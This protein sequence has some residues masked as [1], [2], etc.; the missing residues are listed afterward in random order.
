MPIENSIFKAYD[1]RG[2]YPDQ[3]NEEI[4]YKTG[5]ALVD[6]LKAKTIVVARDMRESSPSL[7]KQFIQGAIEQGAKVIDLDLASTPMFYFA[8]AH[9]RADGGAVITASHNPSKYNGLKMTARLAQPIG[10]NSGMDEIRERVI[11]NAFESSPEKGAIE[12]YDIKNDYLKHA[13]GVI[14]KTEIT[15]KKIAVDTANGMGAVFIKDLL[16]KTGCEV[17]PMYFELDGTFPNHEADPLKKENLK[18]LQEKVKKDHCDLGIAIDGDADRVFFVDEK[19]EIVPSD[20]V[21]ALI[22][23]EIIKRFNGAKILYD[24][25]SSRIIPEIV[26]GIGGEAIQCKV[27]HANIKK[28][29]REEKAVFAGE[30]SGHYYYALTNDE[31]ETY[32]VEAPEV[33]TLEL[34]SL[35]SKNKKTLS[36]LTASLKKY[37][38]SGEINFEVSDI[39]KKLKELEEK[40]SDGEIS[41]LDGLSVKYDDWWFNVRP[42]NTEPVLRLNLEANTHEL[43]VAKRDEIE[44][45]IR[46]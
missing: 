23:Q 21:T 10:K 1:I 16:E 27:G 2:I 39:D 9:L 4:A 18:D 28:Q 42:S 32:Y 20:F 31:G 17:L 33:L 5:R 44:K 3:L 26:S 41:H 6:F 15:P 7:A 40:Y 37:S 22:S 13:F 38:H 29:M 35:L 30:L 8:V 45:L 14:D 24:L 43:M 25:R 19:A 46:K 12:K 11:D 34:L 36:Q